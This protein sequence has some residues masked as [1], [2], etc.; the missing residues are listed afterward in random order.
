MDV[1]Q[2]HNNNNML[3]AS[4]KMDKLERVLYDSNLS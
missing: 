3:H 1:K 4:Q 2:Q